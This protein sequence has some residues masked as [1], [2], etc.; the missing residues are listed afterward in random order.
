MDFFFI[1]LVLLIVTRAFGEVAERLGQPGLVGE[2][3]AGIVLGTVAAQYADLLPHIAAL[4]QNPVFDSITDLGMFFIMLFAGVELQP[5][6]LIEYS[7]GA[8]AVAVCGMVLPMA[9]GIGLGW[10]F[11]PASDAFFAQSVFL[12]TA[13]AVTAVPATVR[14]LVDLGKL[15]SPSGQIIVSA[16]VFDDIL[17]LILLAWLTGLIETGPAGGFALGP[18]LLNVLAFFA[19]TTAIGVFVFPLGG[20]FMRR[21][22]Q[23]EFEFSALLVGALAFSVLAE[24]LDLHFIVGAFMAGL[25]FGRKTIDEPAYDDVRNKTSATTFGF[26]APIFFASVGLHL[27]LSAVFAVPAFV[28]WL[29]LAAFAGKFIGAGVAARA[30][31]L[32]RRES[33]AVGAGMSTRG[34]VELVIA[35]VALEAGLFEVV[36]GTAPTVEYMFSAVVVMAVVTTLVSPVLLKRIYLRIPP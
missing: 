23:K 26:L 32:T 25:F 1:L 31:G 12:G 3:I 29:L 30:I 14:I 5:S 36:P 6:R 28:A 10:A 11:L 24:L 13:L 20:R 17:S 2:L 27:D 19:I 4:D 18:L 33:A 16:A 7:R 35:D 21:I 15:E 8:L 9:F 22:K 34:A